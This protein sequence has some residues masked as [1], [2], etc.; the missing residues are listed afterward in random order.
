MDR[1]KALKIFGNNVRRYRKEKGFTQ[2]KLAEMVG[3]RQ[4]TIAN[5]EAGRKH[6]TS[7]MELSLAWA[8]DVAVADLWKE[9]D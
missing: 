8:L 2:E 5:I 3:V 7:G 1:D 6:V 9:V 4:G